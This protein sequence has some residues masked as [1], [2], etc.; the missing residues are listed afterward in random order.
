MANRE[1]RAQE[2]MN[3]MADTVIK[4]MD[5]RQKNEDEKIRRYEMEKE[6]RDRLEDEK[7]MKRQKMSQA[8]MREFLGKQIDERKEREKMEKALNDEQA[9]MWRKDAQNY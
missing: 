3:R 4:K 6:L 1:K 5:E 7:K 9:Y 2:F 8:Q